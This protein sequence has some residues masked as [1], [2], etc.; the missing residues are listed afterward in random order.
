MVEIPSDVY[1]WKHLNS[2]LLDTVTCDRVELA[3]QLQICH[4]NTTT[5]MQDQQLQIIKV[6]CKILHCVYTE[7]DSFPK[8][9]LHFLK[10]IKMPAT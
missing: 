4:I 6:V 7:S 3:T 1:L 8:L 2:S 10:G 5:D 9:L